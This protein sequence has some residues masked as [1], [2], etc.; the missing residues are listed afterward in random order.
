MV[1]SAVQG[2]RYSQTGVAPQAPTPQVSPLGFRKATIRKRSML[3]GQPIT[4]AG[5]TDFG[6]AYQRE[7]DSKGYM[8]RLRLL[9]SGTET[10]GTA[11]PTVSAD[12]PYNLP[13]LIEIRDSA[14]GMLFRMG[15]YNAHLAER[16]FTALHR[17]S[18]VGSTDAEILATAISAVQTNAIRFGID[19]WIET[20][21][22]DNLGLVPNQ[23]AAFKYSLNV[24]HDIKA[25]LVT[26]PANITVAT[27]SLGP[28]YEYYTV[29]APVRA[30][31]RPQEVAPPFAGIVR[32]QWDETQVVASAAENQYKL[33]P[34]KVIRNLV[35]T[36]RTAAGARLA[37]GITRVKFMY[38]DDTL[39]FDTTGQEIRERA[40]KLFGVDSPAGVYPLNFD[41]DAAGYPGADFRRDI[42]DTRALSQV[43][44]LVTT[45]ATVTKMDII[46]DELIVPAGMS[47]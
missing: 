31:G 35:L 24:Q 20:N 9:Y 42:I 34:G 1:A 38:G 3:P 44:L 21:P 14:G 47:I 45:A 8:A 25:N 43:Y 23:N 39:L 15:G 7:I 40:F 11:D 28:Q 10:T 41:D 12:W 5:S 30:D 46:H 16:F 18:V 32:Q 2:P 22:R 33:T 17:G 4:N 36:A 29:P 27:I 6:V 37:Q 26:T 13:T 19:V